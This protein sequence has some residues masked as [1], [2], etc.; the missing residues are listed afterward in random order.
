MS[1]WLNALFLVGQ[2]NKGL[3]QTRLEVKAC[4][5]EAHLHTI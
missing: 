5:P 1:N 3:E 4:T 2:P